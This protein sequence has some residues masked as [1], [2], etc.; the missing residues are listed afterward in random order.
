[1]DAVSLSLTLLSKTVTKIGRNDPCPCGSGK[2]YKRCCN[3]KPPFSTDLQTQRVHRL[4]LKNKTGIVATVAGTRKKLDNRI[5]ELFG[6][7][8]PDIEA[9]ATLLREYVSWLEDECAPIITRHEPLFWLSIDRRIPGW[10]SINVGGANQEVLLQESSTV[11][12]ALFFKHGAKQDSQLETHIDGTFGFEISDDDITRLFGVLGVLFGEITNLQV[13]YRRVNKSAQL[14]IGE[15]GILIAEPNPEE[16]EL[17]LLY[18]RRR[19]EF[20][21]T[22][23]PVGFFSAFAARQEFPSAELRAD[24]WSTIGFPYNTDRDYV[25]QIGT[26]ARIKGPGFLPFRVLLDCFSF[27]E[28]FALQVEAV[29][30][31]TL[32]QLRLSFVALKNY[33]CDRW[34]E[35]PAQFTY[36]NRGLVFAEPSFFTEKLTACLKELFQVE[37]EQGDPQEVV[38]IFVRLLSSSGSAQEYDPLMRRGVGALHQNPG[39]WIFDLNLTPV[40]LANVMMDLQLDSEM[41]QIKGS[42]FETYVADRLSSDCPV[43]SMPIKPG[44]KL[45][46]KGEETAFAEVDAYIQVGALLFLIDCKAYSLTREYF[47][48]DY[49][50]V[51]NRRILNE[52]WLDASD[53]RGA[54]IAKSRSGANYFIPVEISHVVPVVCSAFPEFWW[55]FD[56]REFLV[57]RSVPRVCTYH[58]LVE[59]LNSNSVNDLVNHPFAIPIV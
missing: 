21:L 59:L 26:S 46:R 22:F 47:R 2:K 8:G 41:R 35:E 55:T 16:T 33:I 56:E 18:D 20:S 6:S 57:P 4:F 42:H 14:K 39:I 58:E 31:L 3:D 52:Q 9:N 48:G 54:E 28:P 10:L 29:T 25:Y 23:S 30:G 24:R 44:L 45:K 49:R 36:L 12:T 17:M 13:L 38:S 43:I 34:S 1:M 15:D 19:Q 40:L 50:A 37:A 11:K 5:I 32:R 53:R 51:R 27:I 7:C